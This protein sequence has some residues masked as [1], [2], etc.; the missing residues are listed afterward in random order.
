MA[1]ATLGTWFEV[2]L[3]NGE[4]RLVFFANLSHCRLNGKGGASLIIK[5]VY[6]NGIV[7]II[8][9]VTFGWSWKNKADRLC[10]AASNPISCALGVEMYK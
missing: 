4:G 10:F 8:V 3:S 6:A 5:E 2:G 7:F 9:L 1:I